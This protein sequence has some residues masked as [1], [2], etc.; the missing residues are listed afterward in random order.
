MNQGARLPP[1]HFLSGEGAGG[2][3]RFSSPP[4]SEG[5]SFGLPAGIGSGRRSAKRVGQ[6]AIVVTMLQVDISS[7]LSA[8]QLEPLGP[9]I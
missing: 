2:A 9:Y 1:G 6:G 8:C 4:P 3:S 5:R 7:A